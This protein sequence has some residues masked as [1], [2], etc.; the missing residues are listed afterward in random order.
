LVDKV[1]RLENEITALKAENKSLKGSVLEAWEVDAAKAIIEDAGKQDIEEIPTF[2][3]TA[4]EFFSEYVNSHP[5]LGELKGMKEKAKMISDDLFQFY[6][7][8]AALIPSEPHA[9]YVKDKK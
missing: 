2:A 6:Q 9:T 7:E 5:R 1:F 4:F 3:C 8:S